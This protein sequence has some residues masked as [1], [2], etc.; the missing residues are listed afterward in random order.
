MQKAKFIFRIACLG[1]VMMSFQ[2]KAFNP[3]DTAKA[4]N[5][6]PKKNIF[7]VRKSKLKI[8]FQVKSL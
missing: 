8:C 7:G 6:K 4:G 5:Q 3:S 2:K 1:M